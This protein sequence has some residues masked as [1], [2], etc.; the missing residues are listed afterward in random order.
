MK[1]NWYESDSGI[2]QIINLKNGK[3]YVGKSKN[4][5]RRKYQHLGELNSNKHNNKYL[6]NSY[7]KYGSNNFLFEVIEFCDI[8]NLSNRE[9]YWINHYQSYNRDKGYNIELLDE[10]GVSIRSYESINKMRKTIKE[11]KG[12]YVKPKGKDNPTSKEVHQYGLDGEF[13]QSFESCHIAAEILGCKERFTV[14]SKCARKKIGSSFGFQWRYEKL[15]SIESCLLPEKMATLRY[16][17]NLKLSKPIIALNLETLEKTEFDSI[18]SASRHYNLEISS[19]AR[20]AR[21]ER[22]TSKKLKMTFFYK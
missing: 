17:N 10:N 9:Y 20:I 4:L 6:Q 22:K 8:N 16:N 5:Y 19:I 15:E 21:G 3:R 11:N 12:K 13:I 7:N 18:S 2:Y 1:L 14:I